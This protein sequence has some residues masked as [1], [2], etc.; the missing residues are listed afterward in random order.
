[1]KKISILFLFAA[2][3]VGMQ[4]SANAQVGIGI[5]AG[6]EVALPMGDFGDFAG[7]GFGVTV[8]GEMPVGPM[9][10][11]TGLVGY[12]MWGGEEFVGVTTDYKDIPIMVGA[13]LSTPTGLYGTAEAGL[14]LFSFDAEY[15]SSFFGTTST[16]TSDTKFGFSVGGGYEVPIAPTLDLDIGA[17]YNYVSDNLSFISARVAI[18]FGI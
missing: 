15:T 12:L 9:L 7:T 3:L 11:V 8:R 5:S 6:A 17:R 16:S 2:L 18:L 14:H 10:K 13:K 4:T 1:M